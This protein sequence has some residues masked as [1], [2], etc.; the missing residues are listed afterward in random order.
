MLGPYIKS[1]GTRGT[2]MSANADLITVEIYVQQGKTI[3]KQFFIYMIYG[4]KC[5]LYIFLSIWRVYLAF[6]LS[7]HP[8]LCTCQIRNQSDIKELLKFNSKILKQKIHTLGGPGGPIRGTH[9]DQQSLNLD[10]NLLLLLPILH[11]VEKVTALCRVRKKIVEKWIRWKIQERKINVQY[12][13]TIY[14]C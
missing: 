3:E 1:R 9:F 13:Y 10:T 11:N 7:S 6:Q 5:F 4:P 14:I 12:I 2:K 8:Y